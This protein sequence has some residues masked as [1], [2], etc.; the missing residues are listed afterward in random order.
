MKS[1]LNEILTIC[2]KN[3][4]LSFSCYSWFEKMYIL[5]VKGGAHDLPQSMLLGLK[6]VGGHWFLA[7]NF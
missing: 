3:V 2:S 6:R 1:Y 7:H 4:G 5:E